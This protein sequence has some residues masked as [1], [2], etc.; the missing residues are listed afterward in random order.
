MIIKKTDV[1][2]LKLYICFDV[3]VLP[4]CKENCMKSSDSC[5]YHRTI[6]DRPE[7]SCHGTLQSPQRGV[8]R[9]VHSPMKEIPW[10]KLFIYIFKNCAVLCTMLALKIQI[11]EMWRK[12]SHTYD[13]PSGKCSRC[14][15]MYDILD[16]CVCERERREERVM[17]KILFPVSCE[18]QF[19]N[20][21]EVKLTLCSPIE[22]EQQIQR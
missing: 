2:Q 21:K 19:A 17:Q 5:Y 15:N 4:G 16:D 7:W 20:Q 8:R 3:V 12:N 1:Q 13:L 14:S 6:A 18:K 22:A 11:K 10:V 9:D